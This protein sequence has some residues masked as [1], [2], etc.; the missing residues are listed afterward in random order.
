MFDLTKQNIMCVSGGMNEKEA[1]IAID[2]M[3]STNPECN[4]VYFS[5]AFIAQE[6]GDKL[7]NI[8]HVIFTDNYGNT[9]VAIA[10]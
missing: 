8:P 6:L 3:A 2:K 10:F 1:R 7:D 9:R 5:Y 4:L